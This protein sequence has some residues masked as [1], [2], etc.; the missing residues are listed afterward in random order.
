[1]GD[2]LIFLLILIGIPVGI[3]VYAKQQQQED[4]KLLDAKLSALHPPVIV[5]ASAPKDTI[6]YEAVMKKMAESTD[7]QKKSLVINKKCLIKVK[8]ALGTI[9]TIDDE[10]VCGFVRGDTLIHESL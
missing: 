10:S 7:G 4:Q 1:M 2:V 9:L 3:V 8:D 6:D 5:I